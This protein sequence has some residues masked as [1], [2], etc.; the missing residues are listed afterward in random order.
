VAHNLIHGRVGTSAAGTKRKGRLNFLAGDK[1]A[2]PW[3]TTGPGGGGARARRPREI[4]SA[5]GPRAIAVGRINNRHL[6]EGQRRGSAG[7]AN[8]SSGSRSA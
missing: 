2:R 6:G 1:I 7:A 4:D 8:C 5:K 3:R